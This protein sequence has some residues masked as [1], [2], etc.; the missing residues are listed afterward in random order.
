MDK[1]W[2]R[3]RFAGFPVQ[4]VKFARR[5]DLVYNKDE[6][7]LE[8]R[9]G[10]PVA[11]L[12]DTPDVGVDREAYTVVL[13]HPEGESKLAFSHLEKFKSRDDLLDF[14]GTSLKNSVS[15]TIQDVIEDTKKRLVKQESELKDMLIKFGTLGDEDIR[16]NFESISENAQYEILEEPPYTAD[17][18]KTEVG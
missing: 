7:L 16:E 5:L 8:D 11:W 1:R 14:Q 12:L 13:W 10:E 6:Q 9:D 4:F 18:K 3:S 15:L 17:S 2:F